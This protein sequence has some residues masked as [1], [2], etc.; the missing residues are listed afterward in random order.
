MYR[1][2]SLDFA[3]LFHSRRRACFSAL[4]SGYSD[5]ASFCF[6]RESLPFSHF[7]SF[8]IA[9]RYFHRTVPSDM[10]R[11]AAAS[12]CFSPPSTWTPRYPL[13]GT[14]QECIRLLAGHAFPSSLCEIPIFRKRAPLYNAQAT[15]FIGPVGK[16]FLSEWGRWIFRPIDIIVASLGGFWGKWAIVL[17]HV[18]CPSSIV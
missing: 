10:C 1:A 7:C 8:T 3:A 6:A 15:R 16:I 17:S 11:R 5:A 14:F 13:A 4:L 12:R 9:Q 2:A 18:R